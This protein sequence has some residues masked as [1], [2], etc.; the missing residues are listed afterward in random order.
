VERYFMKAGEDLAEARIVLEVI[1]TRVDLDKFCFRPD[2]P[3][4]IKNNYRFR[5]SNSA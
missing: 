1:D 3:L 5:L 4:V 2:L